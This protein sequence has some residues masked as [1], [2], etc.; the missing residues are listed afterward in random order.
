MGGMGRMVWS[1]LGILSRNVR[2]GPDVQPPKPIK[3]DGTA[4]A[5]RISYHLHGFAGPSVSER[6]IYRSGLSGGLPLDAFRRD[7]VQVTGLAHRGLL[8]ST[9]TKGVKE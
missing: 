1:L 9:A 2:L 5:Q 8:Q 6:I 7:S 3:S 4:K